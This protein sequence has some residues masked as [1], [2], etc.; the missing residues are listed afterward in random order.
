MINK[1]HPDYPQF[2][3]EYNALIEAWEAERKDL[4]K[5][6]GLDGPSGDVDRRCV[7]KLKQL[8]EKYAHLYDDKIEQ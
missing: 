4:P 8:K 3:E 1:N 7:L 6:T 5:F 2:K